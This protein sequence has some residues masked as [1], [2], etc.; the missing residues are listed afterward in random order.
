LRKDEKIGKFYDIGDKRAAEKTSQA[1]REKTNEEKVTQPSIISPTAF[2]HTDLV[3][4]SGA[5]KEEVDKKDGEEKSD[6]KMNVDD[7]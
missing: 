6:D 1:L 2:L 3:Q 7:V 5:K 4:P